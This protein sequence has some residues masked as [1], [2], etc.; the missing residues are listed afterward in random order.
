MAWRVVWAEHGRDAAVALRDAVVAAK[1]GEPLAPVTVVVPSNHVG[2]ASRRLLASGALGPVTGS[3]AGIA[4]ITFVTTFRLAELLGAPILAA[5]GKR[6]VSTPVLA[7]ALR[8]ELAADPGLFRPVAEH[9]ATESALVRTYRELRDLSPGALRALAAT[10]AR[11]KEVVRLHEAVRARLAGTWSDEEDLLDAAEEAAAARAPE[12]L[13]ALVVHLP[14]RISRHSAALLVTLAE[15]LPA[16]VIAGR[17]GEPAADAEVDAALARLGIAAEGSPHP[18][19]P[20]ARVV[21]TERTTVLTAS[22][23]DEE[24]RAGVRA[25]LDAVRTGTRLD[26]IAVLHASPEPYARLAHEQLH[27]AGIATNG[28]AVVPLAA[29]VAGRTLLELLRLPEGGFR[30]QDVFGWLGAAPIFHAGRWA[31]TAAWERLSREA[32]VVGGRADWDAHLVQLA[33]R[34]A[35]RAH[36]LATDD[37]EPEWAARRA[38]TSAERALQLRGFVLHLIDELAAASSV[39]KRWSEHAAWTRRWLLDLLGSYERR[40]AWPEVER[41]AADRVEQA[42]DRLAALD[43]VEGPVPLAVFTRT[44]EL[45]L[46]ADLA[47]VGR[48]GDGVLVGSVEMGLGLDLDLVVVLGLAEGSFPSRVRDD[49]LLPDG[50]RASTAGELPLR[51][52]GVERQHRHLLA[53]LA[54]ARRQ[55]LCVPRGDLRRSVERTPSRWVLDIATHVSD[56]GARWWGEHLYGAV[57]PWVHHVPSFDAGL[58]ALTVPATEQE[59]RLRALLAGGGSL[60]HTDDERTAAGAEVVASRRSTAFTRFDGNLAGLPV[61]SPV[62]R[63]T[64]PTRLERWAACPHRHLVE[65]LLRAVP[66][67]NPEESLTITPLDKG[68]LVHAVLELFLLQVLARPAAERP[69]AGHPWTP[70]DRQLLEQIGSALCDQYE[71]LGLAGRPIFW[72]RER[73]RIL[74][75]LGRFLLEDS[76]HRSRTSTAPAAVELAFGFDGPVGP[77]AVPLPDG[78]VLRVRGRADRLDVGTDGR[79]HVIDYKTG[80]S[81]YTRLSEDDPVSAGTKL[82]LPIYGLAGRLHQGDPHAFVRAD[83]WFVTTHGQWRRIGYDITDDILERTAATL[84]VIVEGIERGVFPSHPAPTASTAN[85][86]RIECHD[87]DPDGLGI[88]ELRGH[89]DRKRADPAML[90]YAQLAEPLLDHG[91]AAPA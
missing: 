61:P 26:R 64:S 38:R 55:L 45:E 48:F 70:D 28:I 16:T 21:S 29:R 9:P 91:E 87:C 74:D 62:D 81:K 11:A 35:E 5:A 19:P 30:R 10:S 73:R 83:Y 72:R 2:V 56:G 18:A 82:Q 75:D 17:T 3:G 65:D 66:V 58:R 68:N 51:A 44:F 60:A 53:T 49:S 54:G 34:Q 47:R 57:E 15:H 12:E 1:A 59:H 24:V 36:Q 37:D 76:K 52:D 13:G 79:V 33:Q 32:K 39:P 78:R 63:V 25:V 40:D 90:A 14:E 84:G 22:D 88:V 20:L 89:W 46:E 85:A 86:F 6:P 31:P 41:K 71:A 80:S 43:H 27:A 69:S 4:A 77:V 67:E 50:E 7:A 23:G 8:A 42:I